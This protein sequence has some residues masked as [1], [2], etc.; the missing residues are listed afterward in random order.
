[1][2]QSSDEVIASLRHSLGTLEAALS[3][4]DEALV[5]TSRANA[6]EWCNTAFEELAGRRRM[7]LLGSDLC[8]ILEDIHS[9]ENA[10]A[11]GLFLADFRTLNT[12]ARVFQLNPGLPWETVSLTWAPVWIP[13]RESL[14]TAIR[15]I[16]DLAR[17]ERQLRQANDT[18]EEQVRRRTA[19]LR[20]ARD[21]A[22]AANRAKTIF[23]ANMS[24]EIRTPM[25][26]VIGMS[27]LLMD[28]SLDERQQELVDTLHTSGEHLLAL[29]S[30]ILDISRIQA[31]RMELCE[32][33]FDLR[34]LLDDCL[35]LIQP[36]AESKGL[37]LRRTGPE[38][39]PP[40]LLG[41]RMR[42]RQILVNLLSNAVKYT[43][44]GWLKLEVEAP[45]AT[46]E[47]Q[48][49]RLV[50]S[51][52]G[53]GIR[54]EFLAVIFEDFS[55]DVKAEVKGG[56]TGLGLAISRRLTE[57]MGGRIEAASTPGQGS[58]FTVSLA[59]PLAGP[60]ADAPA[61]AEPGEGGNAPLEDDF[62]DLRLLVAEDNPVNQR[63]IQ[64][65]LRKLGIEAAL[66]SD[67]AEV[68]TWLESHRADVVLM[69]IEMPEMDG[70][71]ATRR[72]R[73]RPGPQ[74]YVIALT[75]YSFNSQRQG[76]LAAGMND[77]LSKPIKAAQLRDAFRRYRD[78]EAVPARP[79]AP[80][81]D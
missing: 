15:N 49:L 45:P 23:L 76:C 28:T 77:F 46:G 11:C 60:A 52:S 43:E 78:A 13:G 71:E 40:P 18:L 38:L 29:I 41:D 9:P 32:R 30:D 73:R 55:R 14:I 33:R 6:I 8:T 74:P 75:A 17:S 36:L 37:Q 26:A 53:I 2:G 21:E 48:D 67:G 7:F 69:D 80:P 27:E 34:S 19:E 81:N 1:M 47:R 12:G 79:S 70:L 22:V 57:L 24:H 58:V 39:W 59:L 10:E 63:V 4:V 25:N 20:S 44:T 54:R 35:A 66:V 16:S 61:A 62:S 56:S 31:D 42:L 50:V 5:I 64:L 3:V 72:L 68:L 51:D 65:M